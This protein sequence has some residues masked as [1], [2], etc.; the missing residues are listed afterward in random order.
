MT[1]RGVSRMRAGESLHG[2]APGHTQPLAD[3]RHLAA[4]HAERGIHI[5]PDT[6][7]TGWRG[8]RM[9][10]GIAIDSL[11]FRIA[12]TDKRSRSGTAAARRRASTCGGRYF[13]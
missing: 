4:A 9:D 12:R 7:A 5:D 8:E 13:S 11:L 10:Y 6:A 2:C 1:A 3:W